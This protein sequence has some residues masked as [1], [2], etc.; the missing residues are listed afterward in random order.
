MS[1]RSD[2]VLDTQNPPNEPARRI[3]DLKP[4]LLLSEDH[5]LC[6]GCGEPLALRMMLE[7]IEE[8][9]EPVATLTLADLYVQQGHHE[10]ALEVYQRVLSADPDNETARR[11]AAKLSAT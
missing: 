9:G 2:M 8:L 11:S 1:Q 4:N 5:D 7:A 6:P 10:Q 3:G